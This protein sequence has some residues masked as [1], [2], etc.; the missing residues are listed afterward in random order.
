MAMVALGLGGCSSPTPSTV[1]PATTSLP[2]AL[3]RPVDVTDSIWMEDLWLGCQAVRPA[4]DRAWSDHR[5]DTGDMRAMA[6][7]V[8]VAHA[9]DPEGRT[10]RYSQPLPP[11]LRRGRFARMRDAVETRLGMT[12]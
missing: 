2:E 8:A 9:S 3:I 12:P 7:S 4:Y 11:S 10:C 5:L 6:D 1:T